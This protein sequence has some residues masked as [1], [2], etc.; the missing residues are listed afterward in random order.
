MYIALL[1]AAV[2]KRHASH[3]CPGFDSRQV[4]P[5]QNQNCE[6]FGLLQIFKGNIGVENKKLLRDSTSHP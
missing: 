2:G 5:V 1:C 6:E 4:A 3:A